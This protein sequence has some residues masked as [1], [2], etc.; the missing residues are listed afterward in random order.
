MTNPIEITVT[1][2]IDVPQNRAFAVAVHANLTKVIMNKNFL[3]GVREVVE[4][5]GDWTAIGD[6]RRVIMND[7]S[8][9]KE[10]LTRYDH[11]DAIAYKIN[12][13]KGPLGKL[14]THTTGTWQFASPSA[15]KTTI[16]WRF[17]FF[18]K[19]AFTKPIVNFIAK[20]L[21]PGYAEAALSRVKTLAEQK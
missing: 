5:E 16:T 17:T 11:D 9:A 7:G 21:W 1:T 10:Q 14:V 18:P 4:H 2:Q 8:S 3:P 20:R 13:F 12:D 6:S 19:S 15:D